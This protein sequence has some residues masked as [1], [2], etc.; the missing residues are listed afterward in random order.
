MTKHGFGH[1]R[2]RTY[3][4][5]SSNSGDGCFEHG[6]ENIPPAI[7]L[8]SRSDNSTLSFLSLFSSVLFHISCYPQ[9]TSTNLHITENQSRVYTL[10]HAT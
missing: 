5:K 10:F 3:K 6:Y 4:V 7:S 9:H 2:R 8:E 1:S